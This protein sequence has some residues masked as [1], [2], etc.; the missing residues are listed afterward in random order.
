MAAGFDMNFMSFIEP[1]R[2]SGL[3]LYNA[4]NGTLTSG[5]TA[6]GNA[7]ADIAATAYW[8]KPTITSSSTEAEIKKRDD[9][10]RVAGFIRENR[11]TGPGG[12]TSGK[13]P[14]IITGN[15]GMRTGALE[16]NDS[17]GVISFTGGLYDLKT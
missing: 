12:N 8:A 11:S 17:T 16:V 4:F 9:L 15:N 1:A 14:I 3:M 13:C 5:E 10:N 2:G 7:V 6:S